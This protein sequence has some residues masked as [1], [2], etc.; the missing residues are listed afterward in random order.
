VVKTN[1]IDIV[2]NDFIDLSSDFFLNLW[3]FCKLIDE[4]GCIVSSCICPSHE[5]SF[6]LVNQIFFSVEILILLT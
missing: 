3:I 2:S 5:E 6:E 1:I 4:N